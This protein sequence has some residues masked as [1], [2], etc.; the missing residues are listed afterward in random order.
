MRSTDIWKVS[1]FQCTVC[2]LFSAAGAMTLLCLRA[3]DVLLSGGCLTNNLMEW[4]TRCIYTSP[5]YLH[6]PLVRVSFRLKFLFMLS[7]TGPGPDPNVKGSTFAFVMHSSVT[8]P[9]NLS[10]WM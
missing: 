8:K 2:S 10:Q 9:L 5:L 7:K 6:N 1:E 3:V 4:N